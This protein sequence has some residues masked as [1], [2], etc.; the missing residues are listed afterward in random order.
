MTLD[1]SLILVILA[2]ALAGFI[3][4]R[5]RFDLVAVLALLAAV[6]VGVVPGGQAFAGF[7]H[8]A[9][10][11]VAAILILSHALRGSGLIESAARQLGRMAGQPSR[12]VLAIA[13]LTAL[14]SAFMNNV[15]A[16]ALMLPVALKVA[17]DAKRAP[18]QMLMP[19]SFASLLGGLITLIGT[20]PN[21]II[22]S[23]REE[24]LGQPFALFDFAPVGLAVA[25]VGV[26]FIGLV[27]WRLLPQDRDGSEEI[28]AQFDIGDYIVELKIPE[29]SPMVGHRVTELEEL[30]QD[31]LS[32]VALERRGDRMLAP[33]AY[34]RFQS[35]DIVMVEADTKALEQVVQAAELEIIGGAD[36]TASNLRSKRVGLVE[37]V[38][39]PGSRLEGRTTQTMSLH[40]RFAVNLLGISRQ[41]QPIVERLG[42]VP[43]KTGDVLLLQ[44]ERVA[45]PDALTALGCLPLAGRDIKLDGRAGKPVVLG[46]FAAAVLL[47]TFGL[48]HPAV[49]FVGAVAVLALSGQIR[50]REIY[51][52][53][54]WPVIVLLAALIPVGQALE[55]TGGSAVIAA[56]IL[57]LGAAA[58]AW[59]LLGV[60]MIVTMLL[61]DVMNNAATAVLMAPIGLTI[62]AGLGA[63]PDP[64][65]MAVAV[66]S[67]S[68]Y[69]TPIGHQSNL[70]VMGP[71]G[72]RFADYWRLGLPLDILVLLVAV[73]MIL[74][75]WPM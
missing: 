38:I 46:V 60:L 16:L 61:S 24:H 22:A 50:L 59:L 57:A 70:L 3:W 45:L 74:W 64:F 4:G 36:M 49:A 55:A 39:A 47:A 75:V 30:A 65:L 37:A 35:G 51:E 54:E 26:L 21:I 13:A 56:P 31:D 44:G 73:P 52:S 34:L 71:G 10:V 62:A 9:V 68:T 48:A 1:Q 33:S 20:P 8:P 72:Y 17:A 15:G 2:G 66:G 14:C 28:E 27:G 67:S 58:P 40:T 19:I 6:A 53:I 12:Q 5:I 43:L 42:H 11:T 41:G 63:N 69:L 23:V 18:S 25:I 7:G 32:V 29:G